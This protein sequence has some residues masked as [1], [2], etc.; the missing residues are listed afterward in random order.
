MVTLPFASKFPARI[1]LAGI[2]TIN[3][4]K[5]ENFMSLRLVDDNTRF[6][7]ILEN[8]TPEEKKHLL[9]Y[10]S[11][12][13]KVEN[14]AAVTPEIPEGLEPVDVKE[15]EIPEEK[16]KKI[17]IPKYIGSRPLFME[18]FKKKEELDE[19]E[20]RKLSK[21]L[22]IFITKHSQLQNTLAKKK[23]Y[24]LYFEPLY[25]NELFNEDA[26]KILDRSN[27]TE[28]EQL[29]K[30]VKQWLQNHC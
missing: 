12:W 2:S 13:M 24:I 8:P 25:K 16:D 30:E 27:A 23:D 29:F 17:E 22:N 3:I 28:I 18:W 9:D 6:Y 21:L 26:S 5:K 7:L 1:Y 14:A 4:R 11:S 15:I 20:K 10:V 19:K